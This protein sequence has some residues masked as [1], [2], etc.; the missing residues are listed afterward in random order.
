M[1]LEGNYMPLTAK[2]ARTCVAVAI[3]SSQIGCAIQSAPT[4]SKPS[5]IPSSGVLV[6]P[7]SVEW[8]Y[9]PFDSSIRCWADCPPP[10]IK[11]NCTCAN[12]VVL[13]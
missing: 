11:C 4:V 13:A 10:R 5:V 1:S 6:R 12:S 2:G 7:E 8:K 3:L 9:I